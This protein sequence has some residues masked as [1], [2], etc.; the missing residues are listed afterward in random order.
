MEPRRTIQVLLTED[1]RPRRILLE[2]PLPA[3][4]RLAV[5]IHDGDK[6]PAAWVDGG[7]AEV[8]QDVQIAETEDG[9]GAIR[10]AQGTSRY[11]EV[12]MLSAT[13]EGRLPKPS[14]EGPYDFLTR[15][16]TRSELK[17]LTQAAAS[18]RPSSPI[19]G[20]SAAVL[21]LLDTIDRIAASPA[22][23]L[24]HGETGTG[25][26]LAARAI[27][28]A[29]DR[30]D[31]PFVVVNCSAFQDQLLESELFGHEKGSFTGATAAKPGLFEVA[32]G[33][34]LFLDEVAEMTSAMQAKLLQTL[35]NGELR[36]VGGTKTR[37]VDVRIVAASNKDLKAEVK[38]GNFRQDL[39]FRLR[40]ITL[41]V[42]ALRER[43]EDIPLLVATFL[44][45]YQLPGRRPKSI[46]PGALK[47]LQE[48]AWPG[49][50]RELMNTIEGLIL[51]SPED[52]IGAQDL[53]PSLR[54][55][56]QLDLPDV[57]A[58]LPMSEVERLHVARALRYTK[59]SKAPAA[60]LL[61]IDVKTLNNK[62][63]NYGIEI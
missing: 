6:L 56:T 37:K 54:P 39:L 14:E 21:K 53:P 33:G 3:D 47:L 20:Q 44:T 51:L 36:R 30:R 5:A 59:G 46:A 32:N 22:S 2:R 25:K 26:T 58:P 48:Y 8:E 55:S 42:P 10:L 18:A 41:E 13:S 62:I 16:L 19:L 34:T 49:N 57:E 4:G 15:P 17:E 24:I 9:T 1:G 43:K 11:G 52:E 61:G 40:V 31:K 28:E 12:I 38:A 27:H 35:D 50:V 45:R 60:R 29:S 7:I 23:V 63:R